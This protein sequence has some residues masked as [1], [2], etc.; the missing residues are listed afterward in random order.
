MSPNKSKYKTLVLY[1]VSLLLL[2]LL[3]YLLF[4]KFAIADPEKQ[5]GNSITQNNT[6]HKNLDLDLLVYNSNLVVNNFQFT[7]F[8]WQ[9][10]NYSI[11]QTSNSPRYI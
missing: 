6:P 8:S 1:S 3:F 9:C 5:K 10:S 11:L 4:N 2:F 7:R